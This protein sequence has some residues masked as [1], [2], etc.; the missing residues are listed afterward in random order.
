MDT[1]GS[2]KK[3]IKTSSEETVSSVRHIKKEKDS[4]QFKKR[5]HRMQYEFNEDVTA[6]AESM[7]KK[8]P[9]AEGV[10]ASLVNTK[11]LLQQGK[12]LLG[13]RQKYIK[14]ADRSE[15]GWAVVQEYK[16]DALVD[17]SD[18]E[19]KI[20]KAEKAAERNAVAATKKRK[21]TRLSVST[22]PSG[23]AAKFQKLE[24]PDGSGPV[25]QSLVMKPSGCYPSVPAV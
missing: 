22:L 5:G 13:T 4:Y 7:L 3:E 10:K 12:S 11:E 14:M 18:N 25:Q 19:K 16:A 15:Q 1:L 2:L 21:S 24:H 23:S 6:K 8:I 17:N 9:V 20:E